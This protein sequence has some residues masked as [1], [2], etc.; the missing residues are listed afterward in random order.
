MASGDA[1]VWH[2]YIPKP[3]TVLRQGYGL[4][5]L[6]HELGAGTAVA[7]VA[8]PLA[9]ALAIAPGTTPEKGLQTAVM[10][11]RPIARDLAP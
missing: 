3:V 9:M 7:V 8:R 6:R 5:D 11:G 1:P 10:A 4:A 2:L